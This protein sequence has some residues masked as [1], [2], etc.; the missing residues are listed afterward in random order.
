[1]SDLAF[2]VAA[3]PVVLPSGYGGP[4]PSF[5]QMPSEVQTVVSEMRAHPAGTFALRIYQEYRYE[6]SQDTA[7]TA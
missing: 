6:L 5:S 7:T 3:A 1:L 2:A 4:M